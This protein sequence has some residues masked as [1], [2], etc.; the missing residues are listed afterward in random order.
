MA[1]KDNDIAWWSKGRTARGSD[2][3]L[4]RK[5]LHI[6]SRDLHTIK[7]GM[8][9]LVK[10]QEFD[11]KNASV[12]RQRQRASDYGLKYKK[13]KPTAEQ[14]KVITGDKKGFFETIKDG[15]SSIFKYALL[16][17]AAIGVSKLLSMPGVM[18]GIKSLFKAI[19]VGI[20]DLIS[21]GANFL[22]DLLKDSEIT[23][24]I[25]QMIKSVFKFIAEG[26]SKISD[27][28]SNLISDPENK[29]TLGTIITSVVGAI[30][31]TVLS[32]LDM[33]S[34]LLVNNSTEIANGIITLFVKIADAIIGGL[35]FTEG[36]LQDPV[37][38]DGIARLYV[39]IKDFIST[40]LAQPIAL[41]GGVTLTL[42]QI[43]IGIGLAAAALEL[44][45]AAYTGAI[46]GKALGG[47]GIG[48]GGGAGGK[49]KVGMGR[50]ALDVLM[51]P[52]TTLVLGAGVVVA[53][54]YM[55]SG[56]DG[57]EFAAKSAA[58]NSPPSS[59]PS[60]N[61]G[62]DN[63]QRPSRA[64]PTPENLAPTQ[65]LQSKMKKGDTSAYAHEPGT[66][67]LAQ[68]IVTS[69]PEFSQFTG[70][71]DQF[72]NDN[73]PNSNHTKGL[74]IDLVTTKGRVNQNQAVQNIT[75]ILTAAG[76]KPNEFLVKSEIKGV[77]P[78]ATGDHVHVEFKS[79]DAAEKFRN[80]SSNAGMVASAF[81]R[82]APGAVP[83][84]PSPAGI[85]TQLAKVGD[86]IASTAVNAVN[87]SKSMFKDTSGKDQM[88]TGTSAPDLGIGGSLIS[89]LD[90]DSTGLFKKLDEMTGG[91]LGIASGELQGA[92]RTRFLD[93]T[94]MVVDNSKN[95]ASTNSLG[96]NEATPSIYDEVLL[97]K[98][99]IA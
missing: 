17:L 85:D 78:H 76:L 21:K 75:E 67:I 82:G 10:I 22:T 19:I 27:F 32:L 29:S 60:P 34:K 71:N 93:E 31:K 98:L 9:S 4:L 74:S 50:K 89:M 5:F 47:G 33:A 79:R 20:S 30:F 7:V 36:L 25:T 3:M 80:S 37:F 97:S 95:S 61:M 65:L 18:D 49:G 44:G 46:L 92:L 73:H 52:T 40:V 87:Y 70:F 84:S 8:A 77:T 57:K 6:I 1:D 68:R 12:E 66:D 16:G 13:T 48:G 41:P 54:Q 58:A 83:S 86:T 2:T 72:H 35:K 63:S 62:L 81:A 15:L 28:F 91:K 96:S 45:L 11:K 64:Y 94:P 88:M 43:F 42:G 53:D 26:I 55:K 69:V 99:T 56:K 14:K 23:S 59:R 90:N 24:S 38:R 51:S 39:A